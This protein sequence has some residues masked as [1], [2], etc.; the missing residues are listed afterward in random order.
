MSETL[1]TTPT[2]TNRRPF[3]AIEAGDLVTVNVYNPETGELDQQAA[4]SVSR[5][6]HGQVWVKVAGLEAPYPY[7]IGDSLVL[8][9]E[10][11]ID[12]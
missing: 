8:T 9:D 7:L 3:S 2:R 11:V 6:A 1:L 4:A 12:W 5:K 10:Q